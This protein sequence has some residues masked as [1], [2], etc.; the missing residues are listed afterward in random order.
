MDR[1]SLVCAFSVQSGVICRE[2]ELICGEAGRTGSL[3]IDLLALLS[4]P[5]SCHGYKLCNEAVH[6]WKWKGYTHL[7]DLSS[8]LTPRVATDMAAVTLML[9][10]GTSSNPLIIRSDPSHSEHFS[11]QSMR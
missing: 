1:Y 6:G 9:N 4:T 7:C 2:L 8:F 3:A 10:R 5:Y 11:D